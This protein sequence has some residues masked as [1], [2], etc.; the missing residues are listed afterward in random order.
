MERC[1]PAEPDDIGAPLDFSIQTLNWVRRV[2]L[3]AV[4]F[5][6][7]HVG[8][9]VV[10]GVI[11]QR[12]QPRHLGSDLISDTAPLGAGGLGSVLREGGGDEGGD[13]SAAALVGMSGD[14][15]LKMDAAALPRGAEHF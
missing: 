13:H 15:P 1:F 5:G 12:G 8:Q 14:I 2:Q 11:H 3:G 7:G 9:H 10:L 6:K 4:F